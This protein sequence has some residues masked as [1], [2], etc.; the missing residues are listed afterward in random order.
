MSDDFNFV[1]K[2][3]RDEWEVN[4]LQSDPTNV[5]FSA[6]NINHFENRNVENTLI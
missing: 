5:M 2:S 4:I 3:I 6:L 1:S